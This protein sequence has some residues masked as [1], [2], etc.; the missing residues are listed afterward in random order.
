MTPELPEA[1]GTTRHPTTKPVSAGNDTL[2]FC[3]I[4]RVRQLDV[5]AWRPRGKIDMHIGR[6]RLR[7]PAGRS[8]LDRPEIGI[9]ATPIDSITVS[10]RDVRENARRAAVLLGN[11]GAKTAA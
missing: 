11:L 7:P 5:A 6:R 2:R 4:W 3:R 8:P 9:G 1:P 10:D